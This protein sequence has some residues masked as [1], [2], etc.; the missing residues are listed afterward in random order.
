MTGYTKNQLVGKHIMEIWSLLRTIIVNNPSS[1]D[2]IKEHFIFTKDNNILDVFISTPK[3]STS[4]EQ[5]YY[6]EELPNSRLENRFNYFE[7]LCRDNVIGAAILSVP[8]FILLKGNEKLLSFIDVPG[9]NLNNIIGKTLQ[10]IITGW[11]EDDNEFIIENI[12]KTN[13][14]YYNDELPYSLLER[15]LTYWSIIATPISEN[16]CPK[17]LICTLREV[18]NKVASRK[19]LDIQSETIHHQRDLLFQILN[20]LDFPIARV[21]YPDLKII[22]L[23]Q[24][25]YQYIQS[26]GL[27]NESTIENI[28]PG[29]SL[30]KVFPSADLS[31]SFK[32]ISEM[33]S[34]KAASYIN[35]YEIAL[36]GRKAYVNIVFHPIYNSSNEICELFII[37]IDVT[38]EITQKKELEQILKIQEEFFS[39]ISHEFKTPLTVISSAVQVLKLLYSNELPKKVM[40]YIDKINQSTLQQIRLVNNLLD[41]SKADAGYLKI[42]RE[43]MDI[44]SLTQAIVD[45]VGLYSLKKNITVHFSSKLSEKI[46]AIDGEKY[47]RIIMN[48]LS[49]SI[50][51][52]PYGKSIYVNIDAIDNKIQIE[53]KDVG[54]GISKEKQQIIFERFS[55]LE[56][57]LT[58]QSE[59]TGL[60]LCLVKILIDAMDGDIVVESDP[61][62]GSSFKITLPDSI[63]LISSFLFT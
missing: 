48:L 41:I 54:I 50:K 59:G 52:T 30:N 58:R 22:E 25:S 1:N 28:L 31:K 49:N 43:N 2:M 32:I 61:N 35:D 10:D 51:F 62:N 60:G 6:F 14:T 18:T 20:T 45:S 3:L 29:K 5:I 56:N 53:V 19:L 24:K 12:V 37:V 26:M 4:D 16:G 34:K 21:S 42:H 33:A 55:Q 63:T 39:F 23:N 36:G 15:G 46:I 27:L 9:N 57:P 13:K 47:E 8:D 44:V 17:Y 7:Q 38:R 11:T 40:N